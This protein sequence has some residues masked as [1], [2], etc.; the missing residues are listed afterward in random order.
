MNCN[1]KYNILC[2]LIFYLNGNYAQQDLQFC[3]INTLRK[4]FKIEFKK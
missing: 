1:F 4:S 3:D 2:I